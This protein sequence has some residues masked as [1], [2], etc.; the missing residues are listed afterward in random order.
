M[1][2]DESTTV[3]RWFSSSL[4]P[5]PLDAPPPSVD[6]QVEFGAWSRPGPSRSVNDDHYLILRL[7][8][9]M[10]TV[11]TSLPE[12]EVPK[13][14][15]E[16]GYG[17][18]I[19]DGLGG[20]GETASRLAIS[21]LAHLAIYFGKQH[22]RVDEPIAE[23][24]IDRARRFYRSV[25]SLLV[26]TSK[27]SPGRLQTTLTA[28]Y[29]A[30]T[31]LFFAHVGHS[32]AYVFRDD[33]LMQLT[34]DHAVDRERLGTAAIV[35]A[36]TRGRDVHHVVTET[37]GGPGSSAP[38]IDVERCGLLDGDVV[39]L[40]TNGLTDVAKDAQIANVLQLHRTPG[41]QCRALVDLAVNSGGQDDV[42]AV[43]AHYRIASRSGD[44]DTPPLP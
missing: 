38:R 13:R 17:I 4:L 26:E 41:E 42:T 27:Y 33:Q 29:S 7:G 6:V 16:S 21:T 1:S 23:E 22:V 40:C 36:A 32:R 11:M 15:D 44:E 5:G 34:H 18:V 28:V 43:T 2:T 14:F 39:L 12:G 3:Q 19:A 31:E 24:M 30:G 9:H 10:E 8:R 35:D 37:L 20:S 25:D